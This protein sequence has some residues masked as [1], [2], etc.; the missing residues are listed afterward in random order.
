MG[1]LGVLNRL[2]SL[3]RFDCFAGRFHIFGRRNRSVQRGCRWL[4]DGLSRFHG[5]RGGDGGGDGAAATGAFCS[6]SGWAKN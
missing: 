5:R 2:A 3:R 1:L 4:W 6:T